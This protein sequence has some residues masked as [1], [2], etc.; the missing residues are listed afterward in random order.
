MEKQA[1]QTA[2]V[3]ISGNDTYENIGTA[4]PLNMRRY[5][6]SIKLI[7]AN[8]T[9]NKI[10]IADRLGVAAETEKDIFYLVTSYETLIH[11]DELKEDSSPIYIF[12][13]SSSTADRYIRVKATTLGAIITIW[14]TDEE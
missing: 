7:N 3:T 4:I 10:T 11:P 6:Y 2:K 1:L 5:I 12:E 14:Y 9:T 13:A 8:T